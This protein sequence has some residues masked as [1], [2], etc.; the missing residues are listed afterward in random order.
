MPNPSQRVAAKW[1]LSE[2]LNHI[3]LR[4]QT[5]CFVSL[6]AAG[7]FSVPHNDDIAFYAVLEGTARL[8]GAGGRT[9]ELGE[10]QMVFALSGETH[11]LRGSPEASAPILEF[12]AVNEYRDEPASF[13]FGQEPQAARVLCGRIK[14]RWPVGEPPRALPPL[15][16]AASAGMVDLERLAGAAR[17]PGAAAILMRFVNLLFVESFRQSPECTA[18]F[19]DSTLHDPIARALHHIDM[20]PFS[21]WTVEILARKVGMGRAN[22]AARFVA[23][24]GRTPI[25][26]LTVER[27]RH[28][29]DFLADTNL[30]VA[31]IA[32]RVGYRSEAA[33]SRRFAAHFGISPG[34]MRRLRR[35]AA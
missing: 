18:V 2:F 15:L 28:A 8:A 13:A 21:P 30:K 22:F 14:A 24:V 6:G 23:Q 19:H 10:G 26:A 12:L 7:G 32:E 20:H 29:A 9:V 11:A 27:M 34:G 16:R 33:F 31:E 4:S 35:E 3:E 25:D 17:G 5:W 1:S